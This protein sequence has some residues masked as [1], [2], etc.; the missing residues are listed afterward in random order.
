MRMLGAVVIEQSFEPVRVAKF[1]VDSLGPAH[2]RV[3]VRQGVLIRCHLTSYDF[4]V[5]V[6]VVV[7][8]K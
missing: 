7:V 1:L 3:Q 8:N 6:E 4:L 5:L 2:M